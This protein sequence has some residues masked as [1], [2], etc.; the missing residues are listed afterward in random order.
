[1]AFWRQLVI[2]LSGTGCVVALLGLTVGIW[3][4]S[5]S[6]RYFLRRY[7]RRTWS[8]YVGTM[9]WHHWGGLIFGTLAFTWVFSGMLSMDPGFYTS[10]G[11]IP[12]PEQVEAFTGQALD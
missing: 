8:P 10:S 5:P 3:R 9:R 11:S 12:A 2:W 4:A 6:R 1:A 7:N